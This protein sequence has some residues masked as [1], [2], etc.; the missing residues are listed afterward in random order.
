[1]NAAGPF[2]ATPLSTAVAG[3]HTEIARLLREAGADME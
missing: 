1:V 2:G 3:G